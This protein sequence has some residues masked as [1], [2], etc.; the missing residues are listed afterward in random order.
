[1]K[2]KLSISLI[3]LLTITCSAFAQPAYSPII[4]EKEPNGVFSFSKKWDYPEGIIKHNDGTFEKTD[5]KKLEA[6]DT[7]HMYF[8]ANCKTN[9]Q[10]GYTI[11]YCYATRKGSNINLNFTDGAPAYASKFNA[12]LKNGTFHFE[13][14]IIYPELIPGEKTVYKVIRSKLIIY[15]KNYAV[16]HIIS[17]YITAEFTETTQN[18][19]KAIHTNKYYL[20]G[21]F[22]TPVN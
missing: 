22:K 8:T 6:T 7:A 13:P 4:F 5:G 1:M 18:S 17:G 14:G 11:R 19:K 2:F 20:K 21:Y 9:V 12:T 3:Y 15:Q 16:A 10:G